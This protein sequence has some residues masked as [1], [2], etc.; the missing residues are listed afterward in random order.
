M[1]TLLASI[2]ACLI[3]FGCSSKKSDEGRMVG[4]P[5]GAT[6]DSVGPATIASDPVSDAAVRTDAAWKT[7]WH[8]KWYYFDY[9]ENLRK[10]ESNPTVYVRDDG[11]LNPERP[12]LYP[13][14]LR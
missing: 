14:D 10:F 6:D 2:F 5:T 4:D 9:E 13:H 1:K 8:G 7:Y 11:R 12:K 3:L